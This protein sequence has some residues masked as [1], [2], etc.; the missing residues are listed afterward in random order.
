MRIAVLGTGVVGRTLAAALAGLGHEVTVG[1]R[2]PAAT[3]ARGGPDGFGTW[4][5]AHPQVT[6]T[7]LADSAADADLVVNALSGDASVAGLG[8]A[9]IA[10]DTVLLDVA[11][12]LDASHGM[13]PSLFVANTDSLAEQLQRAYPRLRVV[14][15][16]NT[17]PAR[18][19]VSPHD[20]ADG[21][22][23]TFVC[24]DDAD[25]KALV[26]SL[27]A[28]L[29]HRDVVDLGGLE[30]A[31]GAEAFMLPWLRLWGVVGSPLYT[32]KVVR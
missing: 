14:K 9:A 21:D 6:V 19:M 3:L 18:L 31:R 1:T 2:D 4:A 16:L 13:P 15:S 22:F 17:M 25:A 28:D 8:A 12:P 24:A 7:A 23:S 27:L 5:A 29:G 26:S 11:N 20:L 30:S 32:F 10:D